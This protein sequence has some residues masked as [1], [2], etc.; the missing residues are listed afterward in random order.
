MLKVALGHVEDIDSEAAARVVIAQAR[1]QLGEGHADAGILL[2]GI[3]FD[4]RALLQE[5]LAAFPGIALVGCT[6][7]GDFTSR[8]E[9]SDFTVSLMLFASDDI[10]FKV[11]LGRGTAADPAG[12]ARAA[13]G[14]ARSGLSRE[15]ALCL[16][17][18]DS[19]CPTNSEVVE[20]LNGDLR[21]GCA[22]FGAASGRHKAEA[23]EPLQFC[24]GE[25]L[26]DVVPLLMIAGDLP[27]SFTLS[28]GWDP[29]GQSTRV[30][31]ADGRLV[32]RLGDLK[33][34]TFYRGY[35]GDHSKP[36]AEFP[37]AVREAA[38]FYTRVPVRYDEAES[39][40]TFAAPIPEG[41]E[42]QLAES[43]PSR[44]MTR[45]GDSLSDAKARHG[46]APAAALVFSC[47]ARRAILGSRAVEELRAV[48][49]ALGKTVPI[50]GFYGF[51]EFAPLEAAEPCRLHNCTMITLLLGT[52]EA[53]M[54]AA[55]Q[56]EAPGEAPGTSEAEST[57]L[58]A[59]ENAVL[60]KKL[61]RSEYHRRELE[62]LRD[63]NAALFKTI[64]GEV[65]AARAQLAS[66]KE[67]VERLMLN[68]L[69]A[70]VAE[71]L[72]R[73]G[74]V[75]PVF[76][77]AASVLFTDFQ[78]FTSVAREMTPKELVG[79]LDFYFSA[80][81][82]VIG[83][84]G[85]EKLKTIGDSYM[86]AAGIPV[87]RSDHAIRAVG[88]AWDIHLFMEDLKRKRVAR[89]EPHWE[90]RCGVHAGPLM[91]GVIGEKKF[92]Y[93]IWGDTV[94]IASRL[95]SSCE[96]GS[97]N[98]SKAVHDLVRDRFECRHRGRV[99]IKNRGEI[100]MYSVV[101]KFGA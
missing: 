85:L 75:E 35:L 92:A 39:S 51:A 98:I 68:I 59:R 5:I 55:G 69:P 47:D 4:H 10:E 30:T 53:P 56:G 38:G 87:E 17:F 99:A 43:T 15:E 20:A 89:G 63:S 7:A 66:E 33:A 19:L 21:P 6:T 45:L 71:E 95:E 32:R 60:R 72:K 50:L 29:I 79:A 91:A 94:N 11:G 84:H 65:E 77:P 28:S 44:L 81:D 82:R 24:Q 70:E 86:C 16:I 100:D 97:V 57:G 62:Q 36:A 41:A 61:E 48:E 93:D 31:E 74:A 2:A 34:L 22:L 52:D 80:F 49:D 27:W 67:Q 40:V 64:N 8:G 88:A 12:A 13:L 23:S 26:R 42:V 18:A 9:L 78:G 76:Y 54:G 1:A 58:L 14:A 96:P 73:N 25:V 101:G 46:A 83:R 37:L 3:E 90:L